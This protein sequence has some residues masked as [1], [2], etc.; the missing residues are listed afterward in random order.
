MAR[1]ENRIALGWF[2]VG[3]S[4]IFIII[5]IAIGE[6]GAIPGCCLWWFLS[7]LVTSSGYEAKKKATQNIVY[8]QQQ[9]PIQQFIYHTP[10]HQ[11]VQPQPLPQKTVEKVQ[12]PTKLERQAIGAEQALKKARNLEMARDWEGAAQAYQEAG[13]YHE[14]GRIRQTFL[15]KEDPQVKINIDRIGDTIQDSV[16]MKDDDKQL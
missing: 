8:I 7:I 13:L 12:G 15:E 9:Q 1:G 5:F 4:V 11:Q 6:E 3:A 14:A 2:G 16:V 10:A